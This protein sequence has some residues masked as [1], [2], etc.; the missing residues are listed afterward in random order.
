VAIIKDSIGFH[1]KLTEFERKE[2]GEE[3]IEN[4]YLNK[5]EEVFSM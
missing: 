3:I 2:P 1:H 4:E 5:Q